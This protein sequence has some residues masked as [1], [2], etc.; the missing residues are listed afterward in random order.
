M[1]M[2][3][4]RVCSCV[5]TCACTVRNGL[6]GCV[7]LQPQTRELVVWVGTQAGGPRARAQ[8]V[9]I[10]VLG[11]R[12]RVPLSSQEERGHSPFSHIYASVH[13]TRPTLTAL[14]SADSGVNRL[15]VGIVFNHVPGHLQSS[16]VDI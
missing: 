1:Y 7:D 4:V 15:G 9:H 12:D 13:W 16:P 14:L 2:C 8:Q 6:C 3:G 5:C 10:L 11:Q